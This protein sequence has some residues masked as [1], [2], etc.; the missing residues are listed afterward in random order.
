MGNC[1]CLLD[2]EKKN[3]SV[4]INDLTGDNI[5][6]NITCIDEKK[7]PRGVQNPSQSPRKKLW[8]TNKK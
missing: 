4:Y 7:T 1:N 3:L 5:S 8:L 2:V 6:N